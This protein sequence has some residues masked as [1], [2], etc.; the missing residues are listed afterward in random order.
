MGWE[1]WRMQEINNPKSQKYENVWFQKELQCMMRKESTHKILQG[2]HIALDKAWI[3]RRH[4]RLL[5]CLK[6]ELPLPEGLRTPWR[7]HIS[8][9][10][11]MV[12]WL[13]G[14]S[15]L[16]LSSSFPLILPHLSKLKHAMPVAPTSVWMR[17]QTYGVPRLFWAYLHHSGISFPHFPC[18]AELLSS[19]HFHKT[20]I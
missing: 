4:S 5:Q 6:L 9:C 1:E 20:G 8:Y 11:A 14:H 10:R 2:I 16:P 18:Q 19:I 15:T 17:G 12:M 13:T 3:L 7:A